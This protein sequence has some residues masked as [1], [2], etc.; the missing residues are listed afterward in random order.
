MTGEPM[1]DAF[2]TAVKTILYIYFSCG[3]LCAIV[4]VILDI[5]NNY[6]VLGGPALLHT[7][8][9]VLLVL[10]LW[11]IIVWAFGLAWL[12]HVKQNEQ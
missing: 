5:R 7:A 2:L 9:R 8:C 6:R 11:P 10:G 3:T 12:E 4:F 1:W